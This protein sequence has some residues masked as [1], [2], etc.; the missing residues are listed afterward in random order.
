M[1]GNV[2]VP[3][4]LAVQEVEMEGLE[5]GLGVRFGQ[6]DPIEFIHGEEAE[7]KI[8]V[9]E[10]QVGGVSAGGAAIDEDEHVDGAEDADLGGVQEAAHLYGDVELFFYFAGEAEGDVFLLSEFAAGQVPLVAFVLQE[11]DLVVDKADPFNG[12]RIAVRE[13]IG[14]Y[15]PAQGSE[16]QFFKA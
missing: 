3:E 4:A 6:A 16:E 5:D 8:F 13:V 9:A 1:P 2:L 7:G 11:D 10:L 15:D 12:Y 14:R